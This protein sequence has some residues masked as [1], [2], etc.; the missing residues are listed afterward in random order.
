MK[1]HIFIKKTKSPEDLFLKTQL[2]FLVEY[3]IFKYMTQFCS[4]G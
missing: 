4:E 1:F 2:A 3:S